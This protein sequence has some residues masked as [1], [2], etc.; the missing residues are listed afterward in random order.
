MSVPIETGDP[1]DTVVPS[2]G[3]IK[4][5]D[6]TKGL[7]EEV[8]RTSMLAA[9]RGID[10]PHFVAVHDVGG[11][12]P[13]LY[14]WPDLTTPRPVGDLREDLYRVALEQGLAHDAAF[15]AIGAADVD[16][17]DDRG[18]REANLAAGIVE[19]RL[20]LLAY[21]LGGA[22]CG[23]TFTDGELA[24]LLGAPMQGLLLTCVGVPEYTA[25]TGGRPG[26]P[27]EVTM[28]TPRSS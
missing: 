12:P 5:L 17:L 27:T 19:G 26:E 28:V 10:V 20:H 14:R 25:A 15:V 7:S 11:V 6:P 4:L 23:M 18:Y 3:S 22:A 16:A 2:R 13:G 8:L 1:L 9:M 24:T 21:G